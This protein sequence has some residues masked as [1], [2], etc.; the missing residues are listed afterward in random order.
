MPML[1]QLPA[2]CA[3][4][5]LRLAVTTPMWRT[6]NGLTYCNADGEQPSLLVRRVLAALPRPGSAT[7]RPPG[8]THCPSCHPASTYLAQLSPWPTLRCIPAGL[9]L[10]RKL[11]L[12]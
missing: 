9:R 7:R 2:N 12:L 10:K 5:P 6:V 3:A 4:F 11:G 1:S 8:A